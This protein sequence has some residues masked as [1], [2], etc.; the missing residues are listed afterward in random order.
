MD[1]EATRLAHDRRGDV[2]SMRILASLA[3]QSNPYR[4][5]HTCLDADATLYLGMDAGG[6]ARGGAGA[7][8]FCHLKNLNLTSCNGQRTD[9]SDILFVRPSLLVVWPASHKVMG[10]GEGMVMGQV[11]SKGGDRIYNSIYRV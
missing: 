1:A 9:V 7:G 10:T 6:G 5:R 3:A 8:L 2:S 4:M 11:A